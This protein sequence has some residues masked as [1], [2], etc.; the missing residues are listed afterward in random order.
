M[1]MAKK[2]RTGLHCRLAVSAKGP[3]Q[4]LMR[5]GQKHT[6]SAFSEPNQSDCSAQN[7]VISGTEL[8]YSAAL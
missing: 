5:H 6:I 1:S 2:Q 8:Q 4:T 3:K 7:F